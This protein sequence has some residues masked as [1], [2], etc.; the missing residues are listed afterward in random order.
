MARTARFR[1]LPVVAAP[2]QRT[3]GMTKELPP[4]VRDYFARMGRKGLFFGWKIR[5]NKLSA[6][7]RSKSARKAAKARWAM[8]WT[9]TG[10]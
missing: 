2:S 6:E 5:A 8:P 7:E 1:W 10:A 4:D 9:K 3:A